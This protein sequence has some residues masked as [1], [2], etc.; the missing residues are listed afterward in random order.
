M[1]FT[2]EIYRAH[3]TPSLADRVNM[4]ASYLPSREPGVSDATWNQLQLD[5]ITH[6]AAQIKQEKCVETCDDLLYTIKEYL[7]ALKRVTVPTASKIASPI[8]SRT[9]KDAAWRLREA[10]RD[11]TSSV[12]RAKDVAEEREL[13]L[14]EE[15]WTA[16]DLQTMPSTIGSCKDRDCT[17]WYK[18]PGGW[19]CHGGGHFVGEE[20]FN[21]LE[22]SEDV[23]A[24]TIWVV[25]RSSG[26]GGLARMRSPLGKGWAKGILEGQNVEHLMHLNSCDG[27]CPFVDYQQM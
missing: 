8:L 10:H 23:E 17:K 27:S 6:N 15:I 25:D 14:Q 21:E 5:I 18:Q 4:T 13:A 3:Q 24:G 1:V 2:E 26:A 7:D 16:R 9:E 12:L 19:R 22:W 20:W 11:A